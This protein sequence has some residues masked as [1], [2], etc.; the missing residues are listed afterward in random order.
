MILFWTTF[1]KLTMAYLRDD[2][3]RALRALLTWTGSFFHRLFPGGTLYHLLRP[4]QPKDPYASDQSLIAINNSLD[5]F[6]QLCNRGYSVSMRNNN[7]CVSSRGISPFA[8]TLPEQHACSSWY[9]K[10]FL[11]CVIASIK[12]S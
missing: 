9:G 12:A 3:F 6:H 11:T 4:S 2:S 7:N 8:V 10:F 1:F 5:G